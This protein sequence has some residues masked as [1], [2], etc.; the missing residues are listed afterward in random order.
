MSSNWLPE[1]GL[2]ESEAVSE[3]DE[4]R[5]LVLE[6]EVCRGL[7]EKWD[8]EYNLCIDAF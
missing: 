2:S 1:F 8:C 5:R 4:K 7:V 3:E 6:I